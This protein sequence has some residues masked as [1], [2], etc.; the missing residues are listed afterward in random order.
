MPVEPRP[1]PW[2]L[3]E[4]HHSEGDFLGVGADLEPGTI[5]AAYRLGIFP[6]H[7]PKGKL[8][9]W[10]P[11]PRGVLPLNELRVSK[12]LRQSCKK[13]DI[14][15]N[16]AFHEVMVRCADT[17]TEGNWINAQIIRAYTALHHLGWAHSIEAWTPDNR[18]VGGLYGLAIGGLFAG[19]SMFHLE[20]DASKVALVGLV[21]LMQAGGSTLLDVQWSTDHLASLGVVEIPRSDYLKRVSEAVKMP[22]NPFF[23]HLDQIT[24]TPPIH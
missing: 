9:W 3:R 20:R 22:Q 1:T 18:L 12:S 13:L 10:S 15:V 17:R 2:A 8:G 6:M 19:E 21:N 23:D 14:R 16:S 4:P 24:Q 11:D 5:L 7:V